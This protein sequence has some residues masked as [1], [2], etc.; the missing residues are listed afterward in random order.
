MASKLFFEGDAF[1]RLPLVGLKKYHLIFAWKFATLRGFWMD[2]LILP[3][4]SRSQKTFVLIFWKFIMYYNKSQE[5][6][7]LQTLEF[8]GKKCRHNQH[9][10][11]KL[12]Q[13]FFGEN[14]SISKQMQ[15]LGTFVSFKF[16]IQ[17]LSSELIFGESPWLTSFE[18]RGSS[19]SK[20]SS[21][22]FAGI[23]EPFTILIHGWNWKLIL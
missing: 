3:T 15:F 12:T 9:H 2:W 1:Q 14:I 21:L 5:I 19:F 18:A 17:L 11:I 22:S 8:H 4:L 7:Y 6:W 13:P 16:S 10:S 23:F 20:S